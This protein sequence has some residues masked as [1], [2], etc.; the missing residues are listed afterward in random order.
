MSAAQT[1]DYF[2]K[3]RSIAA[4]VMVAAAMAAVIGSLLDWV[5][6]EPPAIV[7]V[8]QE[9]QLEPFTG[10]EVNDGWVTAIAGILVMAFAALLVTRRR[11]LWAA[12]AFICSMVIGAVAVADYRGIQQIAYDE[13]NRIGEVRPGVGL[14]L[15]AAAGFIGLIAAAAGVAATPRRDREEAS[16]D[17]DHPLDR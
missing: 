13:M 6:I 3:A 16:A 17:S 12:L 10:I 2:D 7:P 14:T 15:V 1:P 4:A 5:S 9:N 8:A 11:A